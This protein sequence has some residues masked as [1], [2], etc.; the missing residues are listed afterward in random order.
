MHKEKNEDWPA[1]IRRVNYP[2]TVGL[3]WGMDGHA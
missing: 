2:G 3:D 1:N